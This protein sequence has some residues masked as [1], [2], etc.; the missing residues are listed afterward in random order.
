MMLLA[1]LLLAADPVAA[2][3]AQAPQ[4]TRIGLVVADEAGREIVAI[5]PDERFVPASNTKLF[6]TAAAFATLDTA[7]P[8]AAGGASV[9]L[10]RHG[11]APAV[12]LAGHGDA[13]LSSRDDCTRDCLADLARAVAARTRV[14]GDVIGDDSAF[15]DE[16]WPVGMSWNNMAGRYGTAV[17]ALTLDDNEVAL[18][19]RPTTPGAAPEVTGDGYFRVDDRV[20][21]VPAGGAA[22]VVATRRP[23]SD[24]LRLDGTIPMGA[25]PLAVRVGVDDPAHRAA[26]RLAALLRAAGVRV[27]GTIG[28]RHRVPGPADDPAV[29]GTA[30]VPHP[31]EP[32]ALA[33]LV[34][35]PLAED[36]AVTNKTS[37]N[38]HAELALRRVAAARGSGS[39]AD[40]RAAVTALLDRAGIPRWKVD[41]ADGSG[42]SSY[43]RVTPRA[44]VAL[45]RWAA[46][47]P[48]GAAWRATLPV[49]GVDGTL[50]RRFRGTPLAGRL[51]AKTGTLNAANALA[52]YV[53]A[54]SGRTLLFAAYANDMP[55][56]ASATA[57]IDAAL[58]AVAA[59][60]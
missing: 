50:A 33:R 16:R 11:R 19:V 40:G 34:P 53:V 14:V 1:V 25:A 7:G 48:W 43:N 29:R 51:S 17:S 57:A 32:P 46:T 58:V 39:V 49:A 21:T 47:Q 44:T 9:R 60:N 5:R 4:G 20:L 3:L 52:G 42:M 13:R 38:L 22:A 2:A 15:P 45:L 10:E 35:P 12:V 41:L 18:A 31:P 56:D 30:P 55:G 6:T 8:D 36:L 26:F 37:Q 23:G 24:V 27:T 59:A 54:A 28:A